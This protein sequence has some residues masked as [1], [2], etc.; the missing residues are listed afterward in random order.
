MHCG[1]IKQRSDQLNPQKITLE[2]LPAYK[3]LIR[4]ASAAG[5]LWLATLALGTCLQVSAHGHSNCGHAET[6]RKHTEFLATIDPSAQGHA[7]EH[8][9][10]RH[11]RQTLE[12]ALRPLKL[13]FDYQLHPDTPADDKDY[14]Q[15][16]LMPA[17]EAVLSR[18]V[19]VR[20]S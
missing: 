8:A 12:A 13:H 15:N 1:C 16:Q 6:A 18:A 5:A 10:D 3:G 14:I 11:Y 4:R 2:L 17:C 9:H 20:I 19:K 7:L